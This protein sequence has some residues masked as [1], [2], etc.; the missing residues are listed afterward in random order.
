MA[1]YK[2][3]LK[4]VIIFSCYYTKRFDHG[5]TN[6]NEVFQSDSIPFEVFDTAVSLQF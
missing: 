1:I 6:Q 2:I 5:L 4:V 3:V